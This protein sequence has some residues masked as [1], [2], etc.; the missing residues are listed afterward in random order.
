MQRTLAAALFIALLLIPPIAS[1]VSPSAQIQPDI[2][3]I[4]LD[5][6][7]PTEKCVAWAYDPPRAAIED[8]PDSTSET[9]WLPVL[10]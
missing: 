2:R 4:V 7:Q 6:V 5:L 3:R 1:A 10:P 9:M 8:C